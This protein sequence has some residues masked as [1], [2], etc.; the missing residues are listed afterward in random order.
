M[1]A[2]TALIAAVAAAIGTVTRAADPP[3]KA[4]EASWSATTTVAPQSTAPLEG[5]V[6]RAQWG[7]E[8]ANEALMKP[9]VLK[10]IIVHHTSVKQQPKLTLEQK[11][12]GLQSFSMKP[13]TVG[14]RPKPAWGDV[15]YHFYI[16]AAARTGEGRD[17]RFMGD[18]NTPYDTNGYVQIVVEG[19]FDEEQPS[20]AILEALA[21]LTSWIVKTQGIPPASITGHNDHA[22]T[23]CPGVNLKAFLPELKRRAEAAGK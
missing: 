2:I 10:A 11:L 7:A 19:H 13:G 9:H 20:E 16:D 23:D 22:S 21:K 14:T 15:P 12:R 18:T 5:L 4:P 17:M 6:T 3:A 1:N 8:P